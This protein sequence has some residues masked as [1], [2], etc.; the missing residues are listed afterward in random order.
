MKDQ[1][2]HVAPHER[3]ADL[4][5]L[6]CITSA[7]SHLSSMR[8]VADEHSSFHLPI[9]HGCSETTVILVNVKRLSNSPTTYGEISSEKSSN[10]RVPRRKT[11]P[12]RAAPSSCVPCT[13]VSRKAFGLFV[14]TS[15]AGK[16]KGSPAC[17]ERMEERYWQR[18]FRASQ[19]LQ[20]CIQH[21][22]WMSIVKKRCLLSSTQ[23]ILYFASSL[24]PL[25]LFSL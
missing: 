16:T 6:L 5:R 17:R 14:A 23:Q 3:E 7:M 22:L 13:P 15:L 8:S 10:I 21:R 4:L 25:G 20:P 18:F 2:N 19:V 9:C 24:F 11:A 1:T 12:L